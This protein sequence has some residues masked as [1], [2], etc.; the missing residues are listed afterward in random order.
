[1]NMN[2]PY[3]NESGIRGGGNCALRGVSVSFGVCAYSC[4][5]HNGEWRSKLKEALKQP[6][7]VRG[8][9]DVVAKMTSAVGIKPCGGCK[10]RQEAL[11]KLV[12]FT[13]VRSCLTCR[14]KKVY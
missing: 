7:G 3:L 1:M 4:A 5:E 11:N 14:E 6:L 2:C 8:L 12:P 13:G 10:K 9:G